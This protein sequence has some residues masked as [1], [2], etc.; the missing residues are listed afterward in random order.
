MAKQAQ[1]SNDPKWMETN[2]EQ[3][4]VFLGFQ[5]YTS[6]VDLLDMKMYWSKDEFYGNFIA[7]EVLPRDRFEK[8]S[9][10]FHMSDTTC[11]N[12]NNSHCDKLHLIRLTIDHMNAE[13]VAAYS[14]HK[15]ETVGKAMIAFH[16]RPSFR[17]YLPSSPLN[18]ASKCG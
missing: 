4:Q 12:R 2:E 3:I 10:Y 18:T 14:P 5:V 1:N 9:Q 6:T 8:I 13:C 7:G 11:Y 16:G 15:E 17:Q